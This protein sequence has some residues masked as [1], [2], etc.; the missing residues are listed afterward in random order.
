MAEESNPSE[1]PWTQA[2]S[3][4]PA[5]ATLRFV[6]C[7]RPRDV[8]ALSDLEKEQLVVAGKRYDGEALPVEARLAEPGGEWGEEE[9]FYA[10]VSL[11]DV[12][13]ETDTVRCTAWFYQ[14]D[15]G[16]LFAAGTT[17]VVAE[18]IQCGLECSDDALSSQLIEA[19]REVRA[20]DP[21]AAA[22]I[23]LSLP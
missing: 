7:R 21:E 20:R 5:T 23:T 16:T 22:D 2:K 9:S 18:V 12:V 19:A 11:W 6:N 10:F 14:V 1:N 4:I 13:D 3:D 15:S 17:D 8:A